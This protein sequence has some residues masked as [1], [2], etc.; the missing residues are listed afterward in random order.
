MTDVLKAAASPTSRVNAH[1]DNAA[2]ALEDYLTVGVNAAG[3]LDSGSQ[4]DA[5]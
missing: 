3:I 4:C 2:A 5:G 1:T